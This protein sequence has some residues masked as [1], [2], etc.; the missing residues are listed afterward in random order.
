VS[1]GLM[2]ILGAI[3]IARKVPEFDQYEADVDADPG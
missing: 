1:G 3:F 2:C